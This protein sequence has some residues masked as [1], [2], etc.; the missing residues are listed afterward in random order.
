M[1]AALARALAVLL[2]LTIDLSAQTNGIGG[3]GGSAVDAAGSRGFIEWSNANQGFLLVLLTFVY[4]IATIWL[5]MLSRR[6][7]RLA[8]E[9]ELSRTRPMV[10]LD[11]VVDRHF[12]FATLKNFGQTPATDVK[13]HTSP[14]L[15]FVM[16]GENSV[17]KQETAHPIPFIDRGVATLAPGR[18]ISALVGYWPRVKSEYPDLVFEGEL[19]YRDSTGRTYTERLV[20]DLS[21]Q[22]GLFSLGTK[23][24]E[25]VAKQLEE[26]AKTM[27]H[28]ATGF[29]KPLIRTITEAEHQAQ[30]T[31]FMEKVKEHFSELEKKQKQG[32]DSP[33]ARPDAA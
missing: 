29:N 32:N 20:A 21:A 2:L 24:I 9:L 33:E 28:V 17:P 30:E 14:K 19:S 27:K 10:I 3:L 6:Q 22:D 12:V 26:I 7:L 23:T 13:V 18:T 8:T 25:D 4:V 15:Q 1:I 5:A 31:A 11:L 16:G